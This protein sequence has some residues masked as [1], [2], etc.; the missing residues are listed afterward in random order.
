MV[1]KGVRQ[2]S[3]GIHKMFNFELYFVRA[4]RH[5]KLSQSRALKLEN[6]PGVKKR[7]TFIVITKC[8]HANSHGSE[9]TVAA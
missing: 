3:T 5:I 9:V 2:P 1:G 4:Q 7:L 6:K 8:T